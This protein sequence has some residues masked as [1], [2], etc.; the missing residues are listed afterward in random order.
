MIDERK[1]F[2]IRRFAVMCDCGVGASGRDGA[3]KY[4]VCAGG[5]PLAKRPIFAAAANLARAFAWIMPDSDVT[6]YEIETGIHFDVP[7]CRRLPEIAPTN[8]ETFPQH[9]D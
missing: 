4:L 6:I 2:E 3:F 1:P 5:Y 9:A 7:I 8:F